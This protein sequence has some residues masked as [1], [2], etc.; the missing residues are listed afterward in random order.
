MGDLIGYLVF[1]VYT[2]AFHW[3]AALAVQK[4]ARQKYWGM[5][6]DL[7]GPDPKNMRHEYI[8]PVSNRRCR[9][10]TSISFLTPEQMKQLR[11]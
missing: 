8:G 4:E 6:P 5:K 2:A 10:E 7:F 9:E 1:M 3:L 11:G